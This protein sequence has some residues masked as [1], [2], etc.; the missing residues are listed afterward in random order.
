MSGKGVDARRYAGLALIMGVLW[1]G[2]IGTAVADTETATPTSTSTLTPTFTSTRTFTQTYTRTRTVTPSYTRTTTPSPTSTITP[3]HTDTQTLTVTCTKTL[4][5]TRTPTTTLTPWAVTA[6][7]VVAYP[8]PA[9]GGRVSFQYT[10]AAESRVRVEIYN[11]AGFRVANLEDSHQSGGINR[12]TTWNLQGVAPGVYT[13]RLLFETP[14]G[15][16][17][18]TRLKKLIVAP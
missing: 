1:V 6:G 11:L 10:L 7:E 18:E 9:R 13:Y 8:N 5:C 2:G 15:E 14:G 16:R 12:I 17:S 3:S 4:T